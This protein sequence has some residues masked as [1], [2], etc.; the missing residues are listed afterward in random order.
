MS[1][2]RDPSKVAQ[3]VQK[4]RHV[5]GF[6]QIFFIVSLAV[7]SFS[8]WPGMG[9]GRKVPL[10]S[11]C[12]PCFMYCENWS[13]FEF[14]SII[15]QRDRCLCSFLPC[16]DP[17][18][19]CCVENRKG[20]EMGRSFLRNKQANFKIH[21][22]STFSSPEE[23]LSHIHSC[24]NNMYIALIDFGHCSKCWAVKKLKGIM[25]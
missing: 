22:P 11:R 10:L 20:R 13:P 17:S 5:I 14:M 3:S 2:K 23:T 9:S 1:C 25:C 24:Q 19:S 8:M 18:Y 15:S 7:S 6:C 21:G 16:L 12:H 4:Q